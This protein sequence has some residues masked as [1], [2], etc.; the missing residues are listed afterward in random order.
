MALLFFQQKPCHARCLAWLGLNSTIFC[1]R[2]REDMRDLIGFVCMWFRLVHCTGWLKSLRFC[3]YP[4][5]DLPLKVSAVALSSERSVFKSLY[6]QPLF[7]HRDF[8]GFPKSLESNIWI[9]PTWSYTMSASY[10]IFI[11][12]AGAQVV[13]RRAVTSEAMFWSHNGPRGI[14]GRQIGNE[15][16]FFTYYS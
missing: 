9:V 14:Y 16:G 12:R 5:Y 7:Q 15:T 13:S 4:L 2:V 8:R 6:G 10:H 1:V 3:D 11:G